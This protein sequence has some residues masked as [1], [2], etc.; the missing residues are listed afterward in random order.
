MQHWQGADSE[1]FSE[2][3]NFLLQLLLAKPKAAAILNLEIYCTKFLGYASVK[4]K[5]GYIVYM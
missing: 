3:L 5:L 1:H 2:G 4:I